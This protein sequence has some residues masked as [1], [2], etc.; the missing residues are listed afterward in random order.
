MERQVFA[1]ET[2]RRE[3]EGTDE[4]IGGSEERKNN[5][6]NRLGC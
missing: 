2:A 3:K 1:G 5:E 6:N 4:W